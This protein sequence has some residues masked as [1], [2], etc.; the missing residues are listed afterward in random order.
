MGAYFVWED[1]FEAPAEVA[2]VVSVF[3]DLHPLAVVFDLCIHAVG[4]LLHGVLDR[5]AGFSLGKAER[6]K[7]Q[8]NSDD[9][10]Q[11]KGPTQVCD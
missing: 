8:T 10:F 3:M 1:G 2:E 6:Q 9:T 11:H 7:F 5:L 4:T